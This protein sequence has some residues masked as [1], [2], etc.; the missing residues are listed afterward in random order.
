MIETLNLSGN[1]TI[2]AEAMGQPITIEMNLTQNG[3]N[4]SG[5]MDSMFGKGTIEDGKLAGN[6]LSGTIKISFQDQPVELK[7]NGIVDGDSMK[8]TLDSPFG[9][10]PFTAKKS[11]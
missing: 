4:A 11:N 8:G 3:E 5:T 9:E 2:S 6:S 1:W 7:L 10:I